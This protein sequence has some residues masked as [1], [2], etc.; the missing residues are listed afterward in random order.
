MLS[1]THILDLGCLR[2]IVVHDFII[3]NQHTAH[4]ICLMLIV[5]LLSVIQGAKAASEQGLITIAISEEP[6]VLSEKL[7]LVWVCCAHA[8]VTAAVLAAPSS[9]SQ[10]SPRSILQESH[11]RHTH[12]QVKPCGGLFKTCSGGSLP[13]SVHTGCATFAAA[14]GLCRTN[15][16]D[17]DMC[18][19]PACIAAAGQYV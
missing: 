6:E 13:I 5:H 11:W 19:H 17:L 14:C 9:G 16:S 18:D 8:A 15:W 1:K 2:L 4:I 12:P 3:H 7:R 10:A